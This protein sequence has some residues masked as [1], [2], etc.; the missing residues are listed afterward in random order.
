MI[1]LFQAEWCP[2]SSAVRER[3]TELGIDLVARQP[4]GLVRLPQACWRSRRR[5]ETL[6]LRNPRLERGR[7]G[8]A[9]GL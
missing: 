2:Y 9:H 1:E 7:D 5:C 3:L 6:R 8:V 4:T